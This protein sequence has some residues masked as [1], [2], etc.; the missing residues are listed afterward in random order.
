MSIPEQA[1]GAAETFDSLGLHPDL[2]RAV[3]D[4]GFERPTPIQAQAIP[5][6]LAGRDVIG[7]AQTGTGKTAAFVL[8]ILQRLMPRPGR[9]LI[10][11]LIVAPTREL[12]L[13]S[14]EHLRELARHVPRIR[15][16]ALFGGVP[17]EPQIAALRQGLDI[18][19]ATPGRLLD[20]VYNGRIDFADLEVFV[21][22]EADRMLDM[23]FLPDVQRIISLL[24]P[25]RQNLLF[26]AT[27]AEQVLALIRQML[28]DP[29]TVQIIRQ[30]T[31]AAGIRHG[32][33]HVPR[34]RKAELLTRLL[35]QPEFSSALVFTRTKIG[36]D[37]LSR[38]L[39]ERGFKVA[40]LH[41]DRS[42]SQRLRALE[43]FR[44]G[45]T[46]VLVATEI[47]ARGLDIEDISHVINYDVPESPEMY[48]HRIGRTARAEATGDA[49]TLVDDREL[50]LIEAIEQALNRPLPRLTLPGFE[51]GAPA[52]P[53]PPGP[54]RDGPPHRRRRRR[55]GRGRR[56][57]G[58]SG[59]HAHHPA[60]GQHGHGGGAGGPHA[61]RPGTAH[62]PGHGPHGH[63]SG[64]HP[65][66]PER[67]ARREGPHPQQPHPHHPGSHPHRPEQPHGHHPGAPHP[68]RPEHPP[69]P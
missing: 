33:Y 14:L 25:K 24:P 48:V 1:D 30:V 20:H 11:A 32:L 52:H 3:R 22:D 12:A 26:S 68:H 7:C 34:Q 36:A 13:Q 4:L 35:R 29:V 55:G 43:R 69:S 19:S 23:G 9:G 18:V 59:P 50:P 42:Q 64:P 21:L 57:A 2:L 37:R 5:P 45:R 15:G 44:E 58:P 27:M 28:H 63:P 65:H 60:G 10:R 53:A 66:H 40:V 39:H 38:L 49:L 51:A 6:I 17:M 54:V 46:Q 41:G 62:G 47:A 56:R 31:P 67:H 8:P 16:A 61:H